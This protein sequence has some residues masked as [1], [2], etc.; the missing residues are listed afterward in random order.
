GSS[1]DLLVHLPLDSDFFDTSGNGFHA[2]PHSQE[3]GGVSEFVTDP[4]RGTVVRFNAGS[5]AD[6]PNHPLLRSENPTNDFSV[7]VWVKFEGKI[8]S[9]PVFMGNK[10]WGSG[11]N[12]GWLICLDNA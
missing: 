4:D 9:D 10:D 12:P 2:T 7:N 6:L 1:T 11:S 3:E 8:G 5:Y